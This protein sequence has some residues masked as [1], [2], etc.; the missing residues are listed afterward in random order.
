M[1]Y[2]IKV[3]LI[4][5][6]MFL[7]TQFIGLYVV[8]YYSSPD[9]NL[10]YGMEPTGETSPVGA[11]S[12]IVIAFIIAVVLLFLL[13]KSNLKIV[14][15]LWFFVVVIIALGITFSAIIPAFRYSFILI[16][17][18][19]ISLAIFKIY[20]RN[21]LIHN[22]T[23]LLIYPGIAAIFVGLLSQ[24]S[25]FL[26]LLVVSCILI[27]ISVYDIWA[28]WHSGIMQKMAKYHINTLK[29]FPGF[30]V[31]HIT[32]T[33]RAK[34]K[35]MKKSDLKKKG[36]KVNIAIL[37]GG[38]IVFPIITAGVVM[39]SLGFWPAILTILGATAGI[40]Y[41]FF[42][43]KKKKFYPAMPFITAG[44]FIGMALSWIIF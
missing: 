34:I 31:P 24:W 20:R 1:K 38:D 2:K 16:F 43:G 17:L 4:L 22:F 19:A 13:I 35:K 42:F 26:N 12:Q 30:L 9:R 32:K 15:K 7:V 3:T 36:V 10:P 41:L 8:N 37:G 6:A 39:A 27:L 40:S 29:I 28:V 11:A 21:I 33:L 25:I 18:L 5:L 14:L 44:M 23:E